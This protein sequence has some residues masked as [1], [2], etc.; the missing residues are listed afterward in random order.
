MK[1]KNKSSVIRLITFI[2]AILCLTYYISS[3]SYCL[4]SVQSWWHTQSFIS[5]LNAASFFKDKIHL[6]T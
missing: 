1:T 5:F 6:K 3:M 2:H 4:T